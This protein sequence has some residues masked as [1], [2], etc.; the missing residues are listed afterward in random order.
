MVVSRELVMKLQSHLVYIQAVP[1]LQMQIREDQLK[2]K[3]G[4]V[5]WW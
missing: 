3:L 2:E 4:T 1:R 5:K